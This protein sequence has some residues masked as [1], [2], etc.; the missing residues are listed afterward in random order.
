MSVKYLFGRL[1]LRHKFVANLDLQLW[2]LPSINCIVRLRFQTLQKLIIFVVSFLERQN[3]RL[4]NRQ[5]KVSKIHLKSQQNV[6]HTYSVFKSNPRLWQPL[7]PKHIKLGVLPYTRK[8]FCSNAFGLIAPCLPLLNLT[9]TL[10][11]TRALIQFGRQIFKLK[12]DIFYCSM[13]I[14]C[15]LWTMSIS[16]LKIVVNV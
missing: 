15:H 3:G 11:Q 8:L 6:K 9:Q 10:N 1:K 16:A 7:L 2:W 12:I 13:V 5:N 4:I 14:E